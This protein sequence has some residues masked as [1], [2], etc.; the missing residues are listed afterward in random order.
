MEEQLF[1]LPA[2][3]PTYD[4]AVW[5]YVYR[6]FSKS[7]ADRA[8]ERTC[9]RFGFTSYPQHHLVHPE[10]LER[11]ADTGRSV[12]SFLET[13]GGA[14]VKIGSTSSAVSRLAAA[15]ERAMAL[16]KSGSKKDAAKALDD[17]DV[18]VRY[19][20]VEILAE[21]DP[22]ALVGRAESLMATPNDPLRYL[23][24]TAYHDH[25]DTATARVLDET[26]REPKDSLNPNVLRI[27]AVKALGG[28][29][30]ALSVEAIAPHAAG[31][32]NNGLTGT[33]IKVLGEIAARDEKARK[34][35]R[36]ALIAAYPQPPGAAQREQRAVLTLAKAVHDTLRE[37]TGKRVKFPSKY[38][39]KTRAALVKAW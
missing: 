22:A 14:K 38:D 2:L 7:D 24:C 17:A 32:W 26:V 12:E 18:V 21:K 28:C 36:A 20:A 6:D 35:V 11:L 16:E 5:L 30:D 31:A 15:E 10:T 34:A 19:R 4:K 8:A 33:A 29:G 9:L 27:N 39:A 13:F 1:P 37:V 23:C 3:A 25:G